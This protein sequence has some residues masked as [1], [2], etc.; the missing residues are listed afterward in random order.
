[1]SQRLVLAPSRLPSNR[2]CLTLMPELTPP[3]PPLR[4]DESAGALTDAE[5]L[6]GGPMSKVKSPES[7]VEK[8]AEMPNDSRQLG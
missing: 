8:F 7:P 5:E 6:N 4:R 3:N 1:M 2:C